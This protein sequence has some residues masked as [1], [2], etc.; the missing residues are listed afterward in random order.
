MTD[1]IFEWEDPPE[2]QKREGKWAEV[3]ARLRERPNK[4]A[5][6]AEGKDRDSH[7]LAG[8]LRTQ[9]GPDYE[10][11]SQLTGSMNGV[12]QAGVWAR[13]VDLNQQG[14]EDLRAEQASPVVRLAEE[15]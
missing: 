8:R 9:F 5:K 12:K 6:I 11:R 3:F 2:K 10:I 15:S 1:D 13:Y 14:I 7:S 4:W